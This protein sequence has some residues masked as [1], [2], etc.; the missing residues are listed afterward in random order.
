VK[1][2]FIGAIPEL[3]RS[4]D[5]SLFGIS[6]KLGNL[7]CPLLSKNERNFSRRSLSEVHFIVDSS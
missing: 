3:M 5:L 1:N 2:F 7:I 4:R 6:E